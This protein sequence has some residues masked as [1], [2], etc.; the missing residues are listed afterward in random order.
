MLALRFHGTGDLRVEHIDEPGT[1]GPLQVLLRNLRA[2]ID[3]ISRFAAARSISVNA[4][5]VIP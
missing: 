3:S 2:G 5:C 4:V 1:P